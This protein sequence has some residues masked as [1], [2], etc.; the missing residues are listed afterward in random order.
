MIRIG[1]KEILSKLP[2]TVD[3][4]GKPYILSKNA[5]DQLILYSAICP[6]QRGCVEPFSK[7]LW[8]CPTHGWTFNPETGESINTPG[9]FL[10]SFSIVIDGD[11][12]Y[13]DLIEETQTNQMTK[14]SDSTK[15]PKVTLVSSA[16]LLI[17]YGGYRILTDP[18]I[19]GP[20]FFGSWT[21][22]PPPVMKV[23]DLPPIDTIWISHEH[24]DHLHPHSLSLFEKNIPILIPKLKNGRLLKLIQNL[25]FNKVTEMPSFQPFSI[26]T[27]IQGISFKSE[28]VW[29]DGILFLQL[30]NFRILNFNDAGFHWNIKNII[31]EVDMIC[32][33]FS[34]GSSGYP[35]TWKHLNYMM[36]KQIMENTNLGALKMLKQ[37]VD[38][39]KP[40][41]LLP[42]ADFNELYYPRHLKYQKMRIK[43]S[44]QTV[45]EFF[46][47]TQIKVLDLI[48]GESWDGDSDTMDRRAGHEKFFSEKF[49]LDYLKNQYKK[50]KNIGYVPKKFDISE[51][52][53]MHYFTSFSGAEITKQVGNLKL[54]FEAWD[55]NQSISMIIVFKNGNVNCEHLKVDTQVEMTMRCPG[56]IVQEIICNDL[57]WD[58]AH[59]GYWCEFSRDPDEYNIALWKLLHAPWEARK[60]SEK[61]NFDSLFEISS[62]TA[63]AD[64]IEREG[65][66]VVELLEKYGLYCS[67]C[68]ASVGETIEEGCRMHGLGPERTSKLIDSIKLLIKSDNK[69]RIFN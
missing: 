30:G 1:S 56:A 35:A 39:F 8:K 16:C 5:S 48:P 45:K 24:T 50:E 34:Q 20:C 18:W 29:N 52:E 27:D 60:S 12:L 21:I 57:S 62:K 68:Y 53:I 66:P 49:M 69:K 6:H 19:E 61:K 17:E 33:S 38:S 63:I 23:E 42:F 41:Y 3:I 15:K 64:L 46:K 25:G 31:G 44:L 47:D 40:K 55:K 43:N 58:E 22:Y 32:S 13:A 2:Y 59:I 65:T 51:A 7:N 14:K 67:G 9:A 37:M 4:N 10:N 28:S 54:L 36:K 26:N 11:Y